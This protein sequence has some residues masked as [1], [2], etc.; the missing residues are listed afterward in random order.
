M[1]ARQARRTGAPLRPWRAARRAAAAARTAAMS[2]R[3]RSQAC[4]RVA[5]AR[6][7][8]AVAASRASALAMPASNPIS[9][10]AAKISDIFGTVGARR[11]QR[12]ETRRTSPAG[13]AFHLA[14]L[15]LPIEQLLIDRLVGLFVAL[16]IA[17]LHRILVGRAALGL[18]LVQVLGQQR[19][20]FARLHDSR[21]WPRRSDALSRRRSG[22]GRRRVCA[23]AAMTSGWRA[24]R[25]VSRSAAFARQARIVF[26]QTVQHQRLDRGGKR[27][28][29]A[30][31]G[32]AQLVD[33]ARVALA[34]GA[35]EHELLVEFGRPG[36]PAARRPGR[37]R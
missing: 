8:T 18:G 29:G 16:E 17:K 35:G 20:A 31:I 4:A 1:I 9:P 27:G 2:R 30:E 13:H 34:M 36:A 5:P 15:F 3:S 32:L 22:G 24:P 21:P 19:L 7:T 37:R 6:Q 26:A 10:E 23:L 12:D 28:A 14:E 25:I 33:D 11:S